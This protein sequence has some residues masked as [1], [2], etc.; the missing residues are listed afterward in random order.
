MMMMDPMVIKMMDTVMIKCGLKE[1]VMLPKK[2]WR[3]QLARPP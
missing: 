2:L 3:K 1:A